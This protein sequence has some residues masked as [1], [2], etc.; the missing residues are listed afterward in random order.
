[1]YLSYTPESHFASCLRATSQ[2][3]VLCDVIS[4]T[5]M[6]V[7][8]PSCT[9]NTRYSPSTA[10]SPEIHRNKSLQSYRGVH[11]IYL[12]FVVHYIHRAVGYCRRRST[13]FLYNKYCFATTPHFIKII[14]PISLYI[15]QHTAVHTQSCTLDTRRCLPV[16]VQPRCWWRSYFAVTYRKPAAIFIF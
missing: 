14:L 16:F 7:F 9:L 10:A 6:H 13:T 8:L 15:P 12:S 11:A 4:E 1:M 2:D 5:R 3:L